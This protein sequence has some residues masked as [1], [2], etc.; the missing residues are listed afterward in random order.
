VEKQTENDW[1]V[2]LRSFALPGTS[3]VFANVKKGR[4]STGIDPQTAEVKSVDGIQHA[5]MSHCASSRIAPV[6]AT[7]LV[8]A[9][10]RTFIVNGNMPMSAEE[11]GKLAARQTPS[12]KPLP[13]PR[14]YRGLRPFEP[15]SNHHGKR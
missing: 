14:V 15:G 6:R 11:L 3:E 7:A 1:H 10:F 2:F 12:E 9:V 13:V 5:L 8:E 4:R